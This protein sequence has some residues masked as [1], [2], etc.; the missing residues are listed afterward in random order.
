MTATLEALAALLAAEAALDNWD[1][2][3]SVGLLTRRG[4]DFELVRFEMS[5]QFWSMSD[6]V[7][8]VGVLAVA[9]NHPDR[10]SW[11]TIPARIPEGYTLDGVALFTESWGLD[12]AGM[13]SGEKAIAEALAESRG[14]AN[15]PNRIEMKM[16]GAVDSAGGRYMIQYRRGDDAPHEA[17]EDHEGVALTG[18][19]FDALIALLAALKQSGL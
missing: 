5:E 15:H 3:P 18:R 19:L 16:I 6:P 1:V 11:V 12:L 4:E 2:A 14:V 13:S 17:A 8:L 10:P 9:V 7:T